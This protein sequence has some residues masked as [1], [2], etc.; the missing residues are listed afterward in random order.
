MNELRETV[1]YCGLICGVCFGLGPAN[2]C[3]CR[4][5]PKPEEANCYQRN[6]CIEKRLGGCWE[7]GDFP[8]DNGYFGEEHGGWRG[9][10]VASVQ[11][12]RDHGLDALVALV[13]R[14]HGLQMHHSPYIHKTPE[15]A[16]QIL[17]ETDLATGN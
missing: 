6:C 1:G 16:L 7:C 9:L 15:E 8:C 12:A 3:D 11:Y 14:K 17:Q 2:K 13:V 5:A 4:T 10:C